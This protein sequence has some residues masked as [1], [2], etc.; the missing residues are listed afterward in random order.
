MSEQHLSSEREKPRL[1]VLASTFPRWSGDREPG[2]VYDLSSRLADHYEVHILAPHA[3]G[4][5]Q[6]EKMNSCHVHRFQYA[7]ECWQ[8]LAYEGGILSR[9][10]QNRWRILLIL[11]FLLA[12]AFAIRRIL[13][14]YPFSAI[15]CHWIIPQ[16]L[17]LRIAT[18]GMR[19]PPPALCTSHGGDLFG[20]Q[21]WAMKQVKRWALARC[22]GMTVVSQAMRPHAEAL[23]PHLKPAVIPMGTDLENHFTPDPQTPRNKNHLLFVGRLV[24][25][26]GVEFLLEATAR[27]VPNY[28]DL[29]LTIVGGGPLEAALKARAVQPDLNGHVEFLGAQP[30]KKLPE[31]YRRASVSIVPSIVAEGGD[32]EGFGLVIVEAMGCGCPVVVSSLPAIRDIIGNQDLASQ[33]PPGDIV[34]LADAIDHVLTDPEAAQ[35][36]ARRA[37]PH[38][39]ARFDWVPIGQA[40]GKTLEHIR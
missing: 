18:L 24:E 11:P 26:K 3:S 12:E 31:L 27:L 35:A 14:Q 1:L 36:R 8:T 34:A 33:Y 38:V 25:K 39:R 9:L 13:R 30:H 15:H 5:K 29:R 28:P 23:A 17:A 16:A 2:F 21:G 32:Q 4:A 10:K 40:Y 19:N 37:L 6:E 7:P 20:L 22:Q